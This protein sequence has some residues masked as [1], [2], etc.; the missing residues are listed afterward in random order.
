MN[1]E[2]ESKIIG[3]SSLNYCSEKK[4]S[5]NNLCKFKNV[6]EMSSGHLLRL[7]YSLKVVLFF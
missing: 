6:N 4:L 5:I 7:I 2:K 1:I 3:F